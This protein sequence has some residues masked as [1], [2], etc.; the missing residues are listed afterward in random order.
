M[1][2]FFGRQLAI[3]ILDVSWCAH[4][5]SFLRPSPHSVLEALEQAH[6]HVVSVPL[7]ARRGGHRNTLDTLL[8]SINHYRAPRPLQGGHGPIFTS[9]PAVVYSLDP[10][11]R[12]T[13]LAKAFRDDTGLHSSPKKEEILSY[14]TWSFYRQENSNKSSNQDRTALWWR[15]HDK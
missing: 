4:T 14:L 7:Q 8:I 6:P 5:H 9:R 10:K 12:N 1:P 15:R 3:G 2:C 13:P 11:E